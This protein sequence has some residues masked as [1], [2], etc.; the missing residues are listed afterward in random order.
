M[1]KQVAYKVLSEFRCW[2]SDVEKAVS[3]MDNDE[4]EP[5]V[6]RQVLQIGVDELMPEI[7]REKRLFRVWLEF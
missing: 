5:R 1:T 3:T 7:N 4:Q 2:Y 6:R